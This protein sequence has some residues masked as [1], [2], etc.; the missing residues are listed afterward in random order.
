MAGKQVIKDDIYERIITDRLVL[1]KSPDTIAEEIGFGK[2]SVYNTVTVFS[3]VRDCDWNRCVAMIENQNFPIAPF[4]WAARR[5]GIELP[6]AVTDAYE[7][8]AKKRAEAQKQAEAQKTETKKEEP[9][10]DNSALCL[11]KILEQLN[12][13]NELLEQLLDTV[14]PHWANDIKDNINANFDTAV[15][16]VNEVIRIGECIKQNTRKRGL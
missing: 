10:P 15:D 3:A 9:A 12:R 1:G 7:T 14:I 11:L 5:L 4:T 8:R 13:Q 2:T 16:R 6:D